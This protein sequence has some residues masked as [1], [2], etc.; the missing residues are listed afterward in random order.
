MKKIISVVLTLTLVCSMFVLSGLPAS[1]TATTTTVGDKF[2]D[3]PAANITAANMVSTFADM[4][5]CSKARVLN[6]YGRHLCPE[7]ASA[8][9]SYVTY[10]VTVPEGESITSLD[11]TATGHIASRY[12]AKYEK[13]PQGKVYVADASVAVAN[14]VWTEVTTWEGTSLDVAD[15]P[16][17]SDHHN[18][19]DQD[20]TADLSSSAAGLCAVYVKIAFNVWDHPGY[21]A[22]HNIAIVAQSESAPAP[23]TPVPG[24]VAS[25]SEFT[26]GTNF[27]GIAHPGVTADKMTTLDN[28]VDSYR[29][30]VLSQ[31]GRHL[32]SSGASSTL[33]YVTYQVD[34]PEGETITALDIVATG[35]ISTRLGVKYNTMPYAKVFV[36]DA[37]SGLANAEWQ[38]MTTWEGSE[39]SVDT[40]PADTDYYKIPD[41][42]YTADLT[43][44]AAGLTAVYVKVAFNVWDYP[45][46]VSFHNIAINAKSAASFVSDDLIIGKQTRNNDTRLIMKLTATPEEI[47]A[48][49]KVGFRLLIDGVEEEV[50]VNTVYTGFYN[51]GTLVTAA[52]CGCTYFAILDIGNV[53]NTSAASVRG[54]AG[55]QDDVA[56]GNAK[57]LK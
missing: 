6:Q 48:Y 41:Q 46:Y 45:G 10:L 52:D 3:L 40:Y 55:T 16:N 11:V 34:A 4:V 14:A 2:S 9:L 50:E 51:N 57:I 1:A 18:V 37:T 38:E 43:A 28:V 39:V 8:T 53:G 13:I 17:D 26:V 33:S 29:A 42:D 54:F 31:N 7:G 56:Y 36:A 5:D 44:A 47:E 21:T 49:E 25:E 20:Y 23:Q 35:H 12:G 19:P 27:S 32:C 24:P 15:Y 30:R 22:F